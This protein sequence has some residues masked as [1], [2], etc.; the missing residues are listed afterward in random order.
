M[1]R[2][3][4]SSSSARSAR[5]SRITSAT[6]RFMPFAPV[7][8]T[9]CAASPTSASASVAQLVRDEAAEAQHVALEDRALLQRDAGH[10]GLERLPELLLAEGVRVGLGVALEVHALHGLA[11]LADEREAVLGVAVDQLR[12]AG[13][14]FAQDAE[15]GERVLAEVAAG[16]RAGDRGAHDAARPVGADD[17]VR[18]DHEGLPVGIARRSRGG[19]RLGILDPLGG[20]AEAQ[21]LAGREARGDEV[22]QRLVLRVQPDS[23]PDEGG[24]V[25]AVALAVEAQLDAVVAMADGADAG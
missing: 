11:P 19:G 13:R 21:V 2:S 24:E 6:A 22:L 4:P 5:S 8:G 15:P 23:A 10:A 17:E 7:G 25:D 18:L 12:R 16:R 1:S 20:D 3:S 9:V 14:R